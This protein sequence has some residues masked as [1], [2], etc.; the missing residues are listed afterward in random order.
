M[1]QQARRQQQA[2][3]E[4][5]ISVSLKIDARES[6]PDAVTK[7]LCVFPSEVCRKGEPARTEGEHPSAVAGYPRHERNLWRL[8][9]TLPAANAE[10]SEQIDTILDQLEGKE[11]AVRKWAAHALMR[12][13]A[14]AYRSVPALTLAPRQMARMA[15]LGLAL[16]VDLHDL[17]HAQD[18]DER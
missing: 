4:F 13:E 17:T 6:S 5:E 8:D 9:G 18:N 16:D 14:Y 2:N 7:S 15:A 1:T 12:V 10:L 3:P 11:A